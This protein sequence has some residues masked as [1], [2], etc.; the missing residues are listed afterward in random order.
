M[1]IFKNSVTPRNENQITLT[2]LF[3]ERD[4]LRNETPSETTLRDFE[5]VQFLIGLMRGQLPARP[6]TDS[7]KFLNDEFFRNQF[8]K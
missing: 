4:R 7:E 3:D 5:Y 2:E 6:L 8:P 1:S